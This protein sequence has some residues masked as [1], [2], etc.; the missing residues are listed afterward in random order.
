MD[1]Q[2]FPARQGGFFFFLSMHQ[3]N[4]KAH[5]TF[6]GP[7]VLLLTSFQVRI[8]CILS[9]S[10]MVPSMATQSKSSP[11]KAWWSFGRLT[12]A[13]TLKTKCV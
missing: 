7:N 2:V 13:L 11:S 10:N 3:C 8:M 12:S 4:F 9:L 1:K 6:T 5:M